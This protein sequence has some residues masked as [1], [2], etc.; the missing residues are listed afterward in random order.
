MASYR[1]HLN[2]IKLEEKNLG[3]TKMLHVLL[4]ASYSLHQ[5]LFNA[6]KQ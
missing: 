6:V 2:V 1:H 5:A 4:T 3:E